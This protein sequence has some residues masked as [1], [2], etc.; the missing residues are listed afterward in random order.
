VKLRIVA[1][2]GIG[3][4]HAGVSP[5]EAG[6]WCREDQFIELV[7]AISHAA[8][9]TGIAARFTFDDG[10]LSDLE[11]AAPVLARRGVVGEFFVC[12]GRI[13]APGFMGEP[14]LRSLLAM[15]MRIG[16]HGR[17]HV[18]WTTCTPNELHGEIHGALRDLGQLL[19]VPVESI[20]IPFGAYNRRVVRELRQSAASTIYSS[21]EDL[22]SKRSPLL[23][24][25]TAT[26][27][28]T[29]ADVDRMFARRVFSLRT[30]KRRT[31]QWMK[32][33]LR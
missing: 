26:A 33:T 25:F 11:I 30:A 31:I 23:P 28:W 10:N 8:A 24:R 7:D 19:A 21:D 5:D 18:D 12:S 6:Y 17:S 27:S 15:G 4:P 2:H 20:A 32:R 16:S 29:S 3:T 9:R 22:P 1:F 14:E 13:G